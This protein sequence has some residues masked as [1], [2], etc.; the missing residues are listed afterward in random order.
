MFTSKIQKELRWTA[1][2]FSGATAASQGGL[3]NPTVLD[4]LALL[5]WLLPNFGALEDP[6]SGA[7]DVLGSHDGR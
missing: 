7:V 4:C 3:K 5:L 2:S 1:C 6:Q